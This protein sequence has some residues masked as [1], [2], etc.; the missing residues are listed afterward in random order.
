M[1]NA[2]DIFHDPNT[3]FENVAYIFNPGASDRQIASQ[4][5]HQWMGSPGHRSNILNISNDTIG[6]GVVRRGSHFY[7]TQKFSKS[8]I[9]TNYSIS[10]GHYF[11]NTIIRPINTI[12][13]G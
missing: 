10:I 12:L 11:Y 7:A 13:S 5:H 2:R 9:T 6:I 4:F 1:A 3:G 8:G